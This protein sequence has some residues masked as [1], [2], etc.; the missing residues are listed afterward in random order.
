MERII[1]FTPEA[2]LGSAM[3]AARLRRGLTLEGLAMRVHCA[4]K[5]LERVE[6]GHVK[7]VNLRFVAQVAQEVQSPLV[8]RLAIRQIQ[9]GFPPVADSTAQVGEEG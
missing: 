3:R 2:A 1:L 4:A 8:L 5:T 6:L 7:T 9:A